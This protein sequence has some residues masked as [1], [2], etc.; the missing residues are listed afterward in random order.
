M[1][2]SSSAIVHPHLELLRLACRVQTMLSAVAAEGAAHAVYVVSCAGIPRQSH[3][4]VGITGDAS[5]CINI[6]LLLLR[7]KLLLLHEGLRIIH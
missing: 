4:K 1:L 7:M 5:L 2:I 3:R 6:C